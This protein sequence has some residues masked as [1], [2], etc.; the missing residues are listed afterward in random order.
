MPWFRFVDDG[1]VTLPFR[2]GKCVLNFANIGGDEG[3]AWVAYREGD[4]NARIV[5][6]RAGNV[7]GLNDAM[8][9]SGFEVSPGSPAEKVM[10]AAVKCGFAE[11]LPE[12]K[13]WRDELVRARAAARR[14]A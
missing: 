6:V 2:N 13:R 7:A 4:Y 8:R 10:R 11:E 3:W 14:Q 9:I 5:L 12:E 1:R